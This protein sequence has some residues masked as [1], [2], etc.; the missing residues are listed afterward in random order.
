[1]ESDRRYISGG[2]TGSRHSSADS[3]NT[4]I[5]LTRHFSV[6][7][8]RQPIGATIIREL[9]VASEIDAG[10][11]CSGRDLGQAVVD[12]GGDGDLELTR[13]SGMP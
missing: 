6:V 9:R 4:D 3:R 2:L 5:R 1:M 12:D 11:R 10:G 7:D 8:E 13:F